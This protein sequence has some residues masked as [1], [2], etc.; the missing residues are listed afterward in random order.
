MARQEINGPA[1][2]S[3]RPGIKQAA[4]YCLD[5]GAAYATLTTGVTWIVFL[6]FPLAGV[7]YTEGKAYV[8]EPP[9]SVD[10]EVIL[11]RIFQYFPPQYEQQ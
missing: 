10:P 8:L 5:Q 11:L 2:T 4:S 9:I 1:L 6:P 3:A 7:P